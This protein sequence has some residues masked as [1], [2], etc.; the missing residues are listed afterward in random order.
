MITNSLQ[1]FLASEKVRYGEDLFCPQKMFIQ[2]FNQHCQEN[3]LGRVKFNSDSYAGPFSG[4]NLEVRTEART[5]KGRAYPAQPFVFGV[6]LVE[7][8][9]QFTDD[10]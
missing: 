1:N 6:D 10:Y 8:T 4:R 5:Y 2:V 3:N 9:L 7:D